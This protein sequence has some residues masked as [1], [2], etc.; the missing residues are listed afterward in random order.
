MRKIVIGIMDAVEAIAEISD[1]EQDFTLENVLDA[2]M[3]L[4]TWT[5]EVEDT[6]LISKSVQRRI[7][8]Q[9]RGED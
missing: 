3:H 7:N 9:L 1:T 6:N 4:P 5:V 2:I 8:I